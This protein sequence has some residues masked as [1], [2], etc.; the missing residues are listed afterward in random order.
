M[1][2]TEPLI[3]VAN[4]MAESFETGAI[5]RFLAPPS[6]SSEGETLPIPAIVLKQWEDG[7]L[8]LFA[9]H[10]EGQ[11][12]QHWV[13]PRSVER[14]EGPQRADEIANLRKQ[15]SNVSNGVEGRIKALVEEVRQLRAQLDRVSAIIED[16]A[17]P[18]P[19]PAKFAEKPT[20]KPTEKPDK[21]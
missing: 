3:S 20:E 17:A 11:F 5:V 7:G 2:S 21:K 9:F 14:V 19:A 12:L 18:A 13:D 6:R 8:Q 10:F 1:T 15:L 4:P 16:A